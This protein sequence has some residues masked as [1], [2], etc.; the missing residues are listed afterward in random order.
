MY[1]SVF[2]IEHAWVE[3]FACVNSTKQKHEDK[4][5][6][7]N[8]VLSYGVEKNQL[9]TN[10]FFGVWD[11]KTVRVKANENRY[12]DKNNPR[13]RSLGPKSNVP[14]TKTLVFLN[15]FR[16]QVDLSRELLGT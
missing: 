5:I 11:N 15:L 9:T 2:L 1:V 6:V 10:F 14:I 16:R 3:Q 7:G 12:F 4:C 8:L 13:E